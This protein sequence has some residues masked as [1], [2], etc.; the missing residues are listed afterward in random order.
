[1]VSRSVQLYLKK[2]SVELDLPYIKNKY[3]LQNRS[4]TIE[5]LINKEINH[6]IYKHKTTKKA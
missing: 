2:K 6:K 1:M 5:F 4:Q 3:G